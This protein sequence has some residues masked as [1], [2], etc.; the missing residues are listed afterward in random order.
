M[1]KPI[2]SRTLQER[3]ER[4]MYS[5]G[6][7]RWIE[8]LQTTVQNYNNT[9]HSSI[10]RVPNK[11]TIE[12]EDEVYREALARR[13]KQKRKRP[14]FSVG[15]LV[16]IPT[17]KGRMSKGATANWSKKVYKIVKIFPGRPYPVYSVADAEGSKIKRR[18][19]ERELNLVQTWKDRQK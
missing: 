3:L 11:V 13:A 5:R 6:N 19:Y 8:A 1:Y 10:K 18:F 15:D 2:F 14:K 9:V 12:N 4:Q 16:R 17:P 7:H